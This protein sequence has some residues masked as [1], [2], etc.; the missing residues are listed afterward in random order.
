VI[1]GLFPRTAIA[2]VAFMQTVPRP[3]CFLCGERG[4][5]AYRH[6]TDRLF[7][8]PG[9]WTLVRCPDRSCGILWLDPM[10]SEADIGEA[11]RAYFTHEQK[12][13]ATRLSAA[14]KRYLQN[15][16]GYPTNEC[17]TNGLV[18]AAR[19]AIFR[20]RFRRKAELEGQAFYLPKLADQGRLLDVG[21]G[22]GDGLVFM[23]RQ[24]WR[25][26]GVEIDPEA[27]AVAR[28]KGLVIHSGTLKDQQF[29]DDQFDAVTMSH[30][31]EHVH[32]PIALISECMRI[33]KPNGMLV[34][35]TPNACSFGHAFYGGNW[36]ALEP[37]R[38]LHIFTPSALLGA[39]RLAGFSRMEA[40][41]SIRG[42]EWI[43]L[44]SQMIRRTGRG[45]DLGANLWLR[46]RWARAFQAIEAAALHF[47]G[48]IAEEIVL[49]ARKNA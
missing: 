15:K 46:R 9:R 31:I 28:S 47:N 22:S 23:S 7:S 24:G 26:E 43:V 32:D 37:P 2:P 39:A 34:V 38:H 19:Q 40:F 42:A 10:P 5:A 25:V 4:V 33:L 8:A 17:Q 18:N 36:V 16:F 35:I 14:K 3:T 45:H 41:S 29:P 30:V 44:S 12:S 13:A 20:L 6:L 21:C 27:V 1:R 49:R 48:T 11:Y